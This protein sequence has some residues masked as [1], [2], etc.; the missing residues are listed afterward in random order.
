MVDVGDR[1]PEFT[2]PDA[3]LSQVG[4]ADFRGER[5]V[6]LVFYPFVFTR[7]CSGELVTLRDVAAELTAA[8]V[9]LL[10]ASCD[11]PAA[12]RVFAE[13]QGVDYPLLSDFWPHGAVA[14]AY[15]V[16][17]EDN[18]AAQRGSFLIDRE[19]IVRWTVHTAM[20]QARQVEDYRRAAAAL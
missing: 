16:F 12:L 1:A 13:Q 9:Q 7:V 17:N 15:G 19:G 10:A 14:R 4:L 6:L 5:A 2:L 3:H 18:G 20:S 11:P 8:G